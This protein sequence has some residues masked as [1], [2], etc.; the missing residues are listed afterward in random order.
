[1][2]PKPLA[3]IDQAKICGDASEVLAR[4]SMLKFILG[5]S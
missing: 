4:L 5:Y 2:K 1:M 3:K